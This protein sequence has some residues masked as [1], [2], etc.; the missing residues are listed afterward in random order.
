MNAMRASAFWKA[1]TVDRSNVLERFFDLLRRHDVPFCLIGGQALNA[2]VEPVVSLDLDV[3]VAADRIADI[4]GLLSG[5]LHLERFPHRLNVSDE[6]SSLRIQIQLD[7]RYAAFVDRASTRA[8]LGFDLPVAAVDDILRGKI[9]AAQDETRRSSKRQK[10][11]A[12]IAR[13]LERFPELRSSVPA[14][15]L[16]RLV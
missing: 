1:V 6:D 16:A 7:P 3:V 13:V 9:W 5:T 15:I 14:D 2:Y 10:D 12:D 8:V 11:L 4:E